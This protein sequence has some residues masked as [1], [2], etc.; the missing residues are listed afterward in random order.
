MMNE[1]GSDNVIWCEDCKF[2]ENP[3]MGGEGDCSVYGAPTWYGRNAMDC[4]YFKQIK[5]EEGE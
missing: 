3:D 2:F 4:P 1:S 5:A